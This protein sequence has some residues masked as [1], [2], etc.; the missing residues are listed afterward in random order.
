[1][2]MCQANKIEQYN[3]SKCV[4]ISN[5]RICS[6]RPESGCILRI[7]FCSVVV[8]FLFI[9]I[10]ILGVC[11]FSMFCCMLLY[12]HSSIAII[13]IGKRESWLLYLI[14]LPGFS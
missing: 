4:R 3:M 14:C 1:M 8:D 2:H 6:M 7:V 13:L 11:N 9:V 10:P 5:A 12:V